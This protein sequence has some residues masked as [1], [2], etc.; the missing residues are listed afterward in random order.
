MTNTGLR[1]DEGSLIEPRDIKVI[2][3]EETKEDIL[4]IAVR[5]KRGTGWCKSMPGAVLPYQRMVERHKLGQKD[6]IFP[7]PFRELLNRV[8]NELGLKY[9]REGNP[10]TSYSF[11]HTYICLRLLDDADI[12][13]VAKNCRT[14]V[15]M[16]QKHYAVHLEDTIDTAAINRRKKRP[17][18]PPANQN[19]G[20]RS[21][22]PVKKAKKSTKLSKTAA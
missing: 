8:L 19:A 2:Y 15:E 22:A 3:D 7:K 1:P 6:R 16:I 21:G 18:K 13:Q 5:G 20:S 17:A 10:R 9:D 12:Y 14:S 4:L 11:R